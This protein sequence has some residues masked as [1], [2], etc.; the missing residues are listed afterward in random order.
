MGFPSLDCNRVVAWVPSSA[1]RYKVN[2]D[3]AVFAAHKSAGVGVLIRDSHGQVVATISKKINALLGP[4]E[5]EMK[6][7]EE[8]VQFAREVG[9]Y[10]FTLEGDSLVLFNVLSGLS[11]P[12]AAVESI[13]RGVLMACG[14]CYKVDF[15]HIKRQGNSLAHLLA[16]HAL[17]IVDYEPW[18]E[19]SPCFLEQA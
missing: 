9:V 6:A 19:A 7:W 15:S 17:G 12:P 14:S 4:L 2:V 11:N 8:G 3:G 18:M 16:K 1:T 10:D 5:V 13:A